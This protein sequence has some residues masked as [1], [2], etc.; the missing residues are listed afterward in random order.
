MSDS[1]AVKTILVLAASPVDGAR[2]RLDVEVREI[3]EGLRRSKFRDRINLQSRWAVTRKDLRRAL[4]DIQPQIVH[5]C[6]DGVNEGL[7]LEDEQGNSQLVTTEALANLFELF[8]GQV[9]CIVLNACYSEAQAQAMIGHVGYAI[10]MS[11][12]I[13]NDAAINFAVGFYD[14]LGG[15]RA[16]EDAY[17]FGC[18]AIQLQ[19]IPQH[20]TPII[21]INTALKA[22]LA[23]IIPPPD[24]EVV[25]EQVWNIPYPRNPF[26]TARETVL[27]EM[28]NALLTHKLAALS[29][30]GGI[31]KTQT[32]IEYAYRYRHEY[33]AILWM[34]A[35]SETELVSGFVRLAELF[36]L[37]VSQEKDESLVI[38]VVKQ[39]LATHNGWLLILDNADDITMLREFLPGAHQGYVLLTTRAQATG[40]Y[41]RIEI[42]K[43]LPE[44]GALLLLRR[45]KLIA[46]QA[47][48][49]GVSEEER[50]LAETISR[51]MDGLP[52]ALDQAA[53]F[54]E[55][56]P[57]SLAEYLQ[58]YREEA[59]RLLAERGELAIDHPSV[60]I[61]F[62]LAFEKVL[63]RNP[64]A[65]DLIWVCAF[66]APDAIPEEIF[67]EG[68][69]ELGENLSRLANKPLVQERRKKQTFFNKLFSFFKLHTYFSH[70]TLDFVKVM[71]E[72]GQFSLIYRN[73][74]N[75]TLDIHR[76]VQEVLKAEMDEDSRRVW[77]ERIVCAVTQ[78]F[79]NAE[80]ANWRDCDRLLPHAKVA[81]D[82]IKQYQ[83]ESKTAALLFAKTG[84]YLNERGQY[85]EAEPL[86]EKA[87]S[88]RQRLLGEEHPHIATSYNNLAGLYESQGRYSEA[89]P[90]YEKA[91]S[92]RQRLLGKEH[93]HVAQ[94]YNN[95]AGLYKSQ[96]RYSEAEPLYEKAL[97]LRQRLLGEEHPDVAQSYNNLALLYNSQGRYS[98]AE[99]LYEKALSLGQRLLGEEHPH[100][101][102]SYNNLAG[103]Y[104]SQGRYSEAEPLY[105]K[106]LSLR[107]RL[108]GKEHPHVA[109]SYNNLALLYNSQGRYNEAEP[110]YE[111]ALSLRQRLLGKEHPHVAQSY[112]NLAL[113]YKSQG[114]Y[115]EA[116]PLYEKALSL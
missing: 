22:A 56:T 60:A 88:L 89:E 41:Q 99:P 38:A 12:A 103:L 23:K 52:L 87:L 9:E 93:P 47:G 43:L 90:L 68:A 37:P 71:A 49:D 96:G 72:A 30:L 82:W 76:L 42:K 111:K 108:L 69:A 1:P 85:S 11:K 48:L 105:E 53:A 45:A 95:L 34:R 83:F 13:E 63:Q 98:E 77:A 40:I 29:G 94:S 16:V 115:S 35:A 10:G 25:Q 7:I 73:P 3:E 97:S 28:R 91:L 20:L 17:K 2:R 113:L 50:I 66:L 24:N 70:T 112:N 92:L 86:Y 14:A 100:I 65:G 19:G 74:A 4:L 101:A 67:T 57:S 32:A 79:P 18:N 55:E 104:E 64:T 58:L 116:E 5:F 109:Q 15:G 78:V 110:L 114:R 51:E 54:I 59:A 61:T 80:Y 21:K 31:G 44:D 107:Q 62:S 26:F 36:N 46:E 106:A 75:K 27:Q 84:Y 39:W 6:G 102:T 8:A 81:I 33:Q